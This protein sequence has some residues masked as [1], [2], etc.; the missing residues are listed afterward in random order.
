M[1]IATTN[2]EERLALLLADLTDRVQ[3]GENVVLEQVCREHPQLAGELRQLWGAVI[4]ANAA[5]SAAV[6]ETL[7][8]TNGSSVSLMPLPSLFG[9]YELLEA[10]LRWGRWPG[11]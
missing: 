2:L 9:D 10:H 5:G 6:A 4:L 3:R 1:S 11:R 7:P 8:P